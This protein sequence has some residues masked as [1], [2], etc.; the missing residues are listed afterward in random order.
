M[1]VDDVPPGFGP[2]EEIHLVGRYTGIHGI[3][4]CAPFSVGHPIGEEEFDDDVEIR[5]GGEVEEVLGDV[6]TVVCERRRGLPGHQWRVVVLVVVDEVTGGQSMFSSVQHHHL[7][8]RVRPLADHAVGDPP[9]QCSAV[10]VVQ[11]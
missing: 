11:A 2:I 10:A 3:D 5:V 8:H 7:E 1:F 6:V 9:L 4:L